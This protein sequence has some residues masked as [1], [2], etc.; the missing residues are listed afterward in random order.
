MLK[1]LKINLIFFLFV[2]VSYSSY[3]NSEISDPYE[4]SNRTVHEFNDKVDIYILRPVSVGYSLLPNPIEDGIS[5]ILQNTGEPINFTN[6][7]LQGEI[8]NA[9]SSLMRFVINSTFGLFGVIDLADKINLKKNDTDFDKTLEKWG[10]EEGNYLVI[11][12]IGPRS[13]RH[14]AS[15][16]VDLAINPLNYPVSYTHLTLP[17]ILLV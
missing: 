14:F 17:T 10:A 5:N 2:I 7:I 9:L 16:I 13:S 12:F 3:G 6:Y 1:F 4:K 8:K 15:S 11:P